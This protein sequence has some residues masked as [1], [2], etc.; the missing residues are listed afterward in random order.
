MDKIKYATER[1]GEFK[2]FPLKSQAIIL[3]DGSEYY[4]R[5]DP[6]NKGLL[7]TKIYGS[8]D[9]HN[10]ITIQPMVSNQILIK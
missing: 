6:V 9:D 3:P 1:N 4:L 5:Y 8:D 7:I 2:E 10:C